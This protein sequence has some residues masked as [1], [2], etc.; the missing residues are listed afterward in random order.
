MQFVPKDVRLDNPTCS[1]LIRY[2]GARGEFISN[3]P[4]WQKYADM[5]NDLR[6]KVDAS[7]ESEPIIVEVKQEIETAKQAA[8]NGDKEAFLI[9]CRKIVSLS[10]CSFKPARVVRALEEQGKI[11]RILPNQDIYESCGHVISYSSCFGPALDG[12]C[13]DHGWGPDALSFVIRNRE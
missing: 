10:N 7:W 13:R 12:L 3:N 8:K 1:D 4:D 5:A 2:D 6:G 9:S 11:V